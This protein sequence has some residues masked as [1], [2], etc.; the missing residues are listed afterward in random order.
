VRLQP[1]GDEPPGVVLAA[2]AQLEAGFLVAVDQHEDT[3]RQNDAMVLA[4]QAQ[5][6]A[7]LHPPELDKPD[8]P[9]CWKG[10]NGGENGP[11]VIQL[12]P[13]EVN[14]K[15]GWWTKPGY[16]FQRVT[17]PTPRTQDKEQRECGK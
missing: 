14:M 5:L 16:R 9:G 10:D 7:I 13:W 8:G 12:D 17:L 15:G 11:R 2:A 3:A 6:D 1:V 4:L